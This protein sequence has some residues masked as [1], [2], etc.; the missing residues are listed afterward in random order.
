MLDDNDI[1]ALRVI[2]A[3]ALSVTEPSGT[4]S[5]T[6]SLASRPSGDVTVTPSVPAGSGVTV[7][8]AVTF[9]PSDWTNKRVTVTVVDDST[10]QPRRTAKITHTVA[11]SAD[12]QYDGLDAPSVSVTVVDDDET[13]ASLARVDSGGIDEAGSTAAARQAVF[14]VGLNRALGS[15]E[16][17]V[18][19][20]VFSG[21]GI[22]GGDFTL[23]LDTSGGRSSG[24]TLVWVRG[25]L[26]AGLRFANGAQTAH[27]VVTAAA[28]SVDE[29]AESLSVALGNQALFDSVTQSVDGGVGPAPGSAAVVVPVADGDA[30][31]VVT[32]SGGS[33]TA[34][35][36]GDSTSTVSL[37]VSLSRALVAGQKLS[38]PLT[39]AGGV[40][41]DDL[42][43]ALSGTPSGVSLAQNTVT[44]TGVSATSATLTASAADDADADDEQITVTIPTA[45]AGF[46]SEGLA[47]TLSGAVSGTVRINIAD[48]DD[49]SLLSRST[50][51]VTEGG[52]AT[53]TVRLAARPAGRVTVTPA[54]GNASVVSVSAPLVF[55][56]SDWN[57]P[58]TVTVTAADNA[59]DDPGADRTVTVTHSVAPAFASDSGIE[60][61]DVTVTVADDEA[62]TVTVAAGAAAILE[63]GGSTEVTVT[64]SRALVAGERVDVPLTVTGAGI[65]SSDYTL[66]LKTAT[67]S[68]NVGVAV[69]S[70]KPLSGT[71]PVLEFTEGAQTATLVLSAAGDGTDESPGETVTVALA[72]QSVFDAQTGTTVGG[73]AAPDPDGSAAAIVEIVDDD[74]A[75]G[76]RVVE[77]GGGTRVAEVVSSDDFDTDEYLVRLTAAPTGDGDG[78]RQRVRAGSERRARGVLLGDQS[79]DVRCVELVEAPDGRRSRRQRQHRPCR[80]VVDAHDHSHRV[81]L[82]RREHCAV[83]CCDGGGRADVGDADR[84]RHGS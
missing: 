45:A 75:A 72:A 84:R 56:V 69:S 22:T 36:E 67:S 1:P 73:G 80:G 9:T 8:G 48:D 62:T 82:H 63:T 15:G 64:L 59:V 19:P 83:G 41:G 28:D 55:N 58:Q 3:G 47:D 49:G 43:L 10:D 54:S 25:T 23:S 12:A 20:L 31:L 42:A 81:G 74:G 79:A 51:P 7:S 70:T 53:Y 13:V 44:F 66:T 32:L 35:D 57:D 5:Y 6:L 14:T 71:A 40:L 76:V 33:S 77:T 26:S 78:D 50:V 65:T 11:S 68:V 34:I 24:V 2:G 52:T 21:T 18:V 27:L 37:T 39:F 30:P 38:V 29:P 4:A 61:G 16:S 60:V 46:T 17:A